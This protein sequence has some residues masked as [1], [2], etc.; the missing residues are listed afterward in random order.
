MVD[1]TYQDHVVLDQEQF[2]L[3]LITL[4]KEQVD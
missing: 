4:G 2:N 3:Q 1:V